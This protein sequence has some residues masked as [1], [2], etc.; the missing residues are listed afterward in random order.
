[1][2]KREHAK[3]TQKHKAGLKRITDTRI[4]AAFKSD[5]RY[6]YDTRRVEFYINAKRTGGTFYDVVY[7]GKTRQRTKLAKWPAVTAQALFEELPAIRANALADRQAS[8]TVSA[9]KTGCDV[10]MW[11][12]QHIEADN[13]YSTAYVSTA[14]SYIANHLLRV[15]NSVKL[16]QINRRLLY[17]ELYL[18]M[19]A[20]YALSTIQGVLGVLKT[21]LTRAKTLGL[22]AS[23]P[24]SHVTL[25][26]FTTSRPNIQPGKL[27]PHQLSL[28]V[29]V[30]H[31]QPQN[32]KVFFLLQL[33]HGTRIGETSL[34]EH[35]H[36]SHETLE[37]Y[38][39]DTNTKGKKEHRLPV[40]QQAIDLVK[41]LPQIG[42]HLFTNKNGQ[43][44]T[45]RT[46][47]RW[48]QVLSNDLKLKFTSHDMR[49]LARDCWQ[50]MGIDWIVGEMLLNHER[51]GL[52]KRYM[53]AHSRE[54]MRKA[55]EKWKDVCRNNGMK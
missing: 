5:K 20:D 48:Y 2:N 30:I 52:D 46:V 24:I 41:S 45:K 42:T 23:N 53:H 34:A 44:I 18:P 3:N 51:D 40:T 35:E 17:Q 21:A 14:S 7:K 31:K 1:M 13:T 36:F 19:Q 27:K 22:I 33:L 26:S 38:L 29:G 47:G 32:R 25:K 15:L 37:W 28:L 11:F 49:K 9:F 55:L 50:D 54:Q 10:L 43:P 6:L 16:S 12:M 4:R 39:P 8:L